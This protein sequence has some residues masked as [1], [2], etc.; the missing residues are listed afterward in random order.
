MEPN[1]C[2]PSGPT[3]DVSSNCA[4][5]NPPL[6]PGV[7]SALLLH[8]SIHFETFCNKTNN[9]QQQIH[10][11]IST[12]VSTIYPTY[13]NCLRHHAIPIPTPKRISITQY[14]GTLLREPHVSIINNNNNNTTRGPQR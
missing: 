9:Q 3:S 14:R 7:S 8:A 12:F 2:P 11:D 4:A 13:S 10:H 6:Q 1:Q 5:D